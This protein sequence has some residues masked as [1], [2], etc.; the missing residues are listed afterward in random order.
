MH[1]LIALNDE[2]SAHGVNS[3]FPTRNQPNPVNLPLLYR[4]KNCFNP[5]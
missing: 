1:T 2:N 3:N 5:Y 4:R